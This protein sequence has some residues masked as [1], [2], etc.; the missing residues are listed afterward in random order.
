MV[1]LAEALGWKGPPWWW[2][3]PLLLVAGTTVGLVITRLPGTGGH[4]P[5]S[6]LH[7]GGISPEPCRA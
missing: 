6:G 7:P 5:A 2:P 3:L 1:R 4:V